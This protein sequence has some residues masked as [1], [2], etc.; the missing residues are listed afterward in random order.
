MGVENQQKNSNSKVA[1]VNHVE[2]TYVEKATLS[3]ASTKLTEITMVN[4]VA[5]TYLRTVEIHGSRWSRR[6]Y[7][8]LDRVTANERPF[9]ERARRALAG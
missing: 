1:T 3:I 5:G 7:K 9:V 4:L 2:K 6:N 8:P